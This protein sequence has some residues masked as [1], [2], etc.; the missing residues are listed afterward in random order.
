MNRYKKLLI[1]AIL[2]SITSIALVTGLTFNSNT[3]EALSR[4]RPEYILDAVFTHIL[5]YII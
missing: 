2:I 1:A 4:I 5:F 3:V